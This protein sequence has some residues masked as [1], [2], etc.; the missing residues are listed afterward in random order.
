MSDYEDDFDQPDDFRPN[1]TATTL[2]Q[3]RGSQD[4][5]VKITSRSYVLKQKSGV[6]MH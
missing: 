3:P 2:Q 1:P 5:L 4:N 6:A